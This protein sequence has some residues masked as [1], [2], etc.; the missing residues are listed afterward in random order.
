MGNVKR[1][2]A[3]GVFAAAFCA[4]QSGTAE[5]VN[6]LPSH[7]LHLSTTVA[8]NCVTLV[9]P[10]F[11]FTLGIAD[12]Q[13]PNH[14]YESSSTISVSC[15]KGATVAIG[16]DGGLYSAFATGSKFGH[17]AMRF[18]NGSTYLIYD[19]CHD[20]ACSQLWANSGYTYLSKADTS[21]S[22]AVYARI[23]SGQHSVSLGNYSDSVTTTVNF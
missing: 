20:Q 22:S 8:S 6:A 19:L 21:A 3:A 15:T 5:A 4:V 7:P 12:I 11:S 18:S 14:T 1:L 23:I 17:R 2:L 13:S 16:M 9:T 10:A